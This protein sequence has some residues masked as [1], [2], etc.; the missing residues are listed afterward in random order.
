[1]KFDMDD[2]AK[3][4]LPDTFRNRFL[5]FLGEHVLPDLSGRILSLPSSCSSY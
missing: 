3:V 5:E 2:I 1:V 4:L